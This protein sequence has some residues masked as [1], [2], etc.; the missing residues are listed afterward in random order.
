MP[1]LY[2]HL[3]RERGPLPWLETPLVETGVL[4][5]VQMTSFAVAASFD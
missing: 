5:M 2:D 3:L 1:S 4:I